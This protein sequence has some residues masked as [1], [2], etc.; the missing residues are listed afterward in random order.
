MI[1]F[2]SAY[3]A[4]ERNPAR[5]E[6]GMSAGTTATTLRT[7]PP[8]PPRRSDPADCTGAQCRCAQADTLIPGQSGR[9]IR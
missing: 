9:V 8:P 4:P 5:L 2:R 6:I 1:T 3:L 7:P